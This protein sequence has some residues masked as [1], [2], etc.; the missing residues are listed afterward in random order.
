MK[1][2]LNAFPFGGSR[3]EYQKS[4]LVMAGSDPDRFQ[5]ALHLLVERAQI[6]DAGGMEGIA[7]S[8]QHFNV[9]GLPEVTTNPIL[10]DAAIAQATSNLKVGQLGLTLTSHHPLRVAED[11]A[12]LDHMTRGRM[13]C[14][15][16]RGNASRWVDTL[17]LP[18]GTASTD[19]DKSAAD[20]ANLRA[21]QEAW[22]II[23]LA[24]TSE[25]FS[26]QGEF[27]TVPAPGVQWNY[28]VTAT[29]G[30]G[31]A[32]DGSLEAVGIVPRPFQRP[33]PRIYVPL[34]FRMTT[35]LFWI[36][37]GATAVCYAAS[38]DFMRTAQEVLSARA[39]EV[40]A[41]RA[42]PPLAPGAFLLVGRTAEDVQ[43]LVDDYEWLFSTAYTVPPFN[44]PRGRM[45]VGT[46]DEVSRQIEDLL[47]IAPFEE[48]FIWHNIGIHD[49]QLETSSLEVFLDKVV[50]RFS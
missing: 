12:M 5:A 35:A 49:R 36:G 10:F 42:A 38:D 9:E 13:F 34:A 8:E 1:F 22:A 31:M 47:Q 19:S 39:D 28:P 30:Q 3:K 25:T 23:K 33:Y 4:G 37:E 32:A 43:E 2:F 48:M 20:Q 16:T 50:P 29:F 26:Y 40:G 41:T 44:V 24:W 15:F 6:A 17:G 18:F 46:P 45:L 11:L 14:G 21:I 7:F 27:W